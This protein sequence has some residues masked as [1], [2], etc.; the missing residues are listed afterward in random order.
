MKKIYLLIITF[1]LLFSSQEADAQFWKKKEPPPKKKPVPVKPKE[2]VKAPP[3][4][5]TRD[6]EYP[7]TVIKDRYRIDVLLPLYLDELVKDSKPVSKD[8]IPEKSQNAVNFYEGMK[9][10]AD[11]LTKLG[12][13]I[14]L[15]VHDITQKELAPDVLIKGDVLAES[16]L[17]IGALQSYQIK[18]L[19]NYAAKRKVN[20]VSIL[21][22]AD[23]G[24]MN[25]PFFTITQPTL[26]THIKKLRAE[27][28]KKYP[29]QKIHLFYRTNPS[30][31]SAAYRYTFE[32]AEKR[33][34][35]LLINTLPDYARLSPLFDSAGTNVIMMPVLDYNYAQSVIEQL[36][37]LFPS[38]RFE[39]IGLPSW[40]SMASLRKA[41]AFP[42]TAVSISTPFNFD[43]NSPSIT[44]VA[45]AYKNSY[46][47]K[48]NETALRGY[49]SLMWYAY[50][51]KRYGT[52]FNEKMKDNSVSFT[53]Y[54]ISPQWTES[55][56]LM[57]NENT[58]YYIY[59]YQGGSFSVSDNL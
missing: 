26:I 43:M 22:P 54:Q 3:K 55:N 39:V 30:I 47:G 7:K 59:H 50:L 25:N 53:K 40:K 31:D 4:K 34:D 32:D 41:D 21:S 48:I 23:A 33:F 29:D 44:N 36:Y 56:D 5:K 16:D 20:L 12:Y 11:T 58:R 15:Y 57:Y 27:V 45:K 9:L 19:A 6:I 10:A 42:N 37:Y 8:Y 2:P 46:A 35:K 18:P 28:L 14:D 52:V 51:L 24:V 17:I 49:E 1:F 13:N 38:Y